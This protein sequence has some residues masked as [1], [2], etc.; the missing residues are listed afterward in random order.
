VQEKID[1]KRFHQLV[2]IQGEIGL[3]L[4]A[5]EFEMLLLLSSFH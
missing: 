3:V 5:V 2:L 1:E 4:A